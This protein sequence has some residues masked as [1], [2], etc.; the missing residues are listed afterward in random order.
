MARKVHGAKKAAKGSRAKAA[1]V[2]RVKPPNKGIK[3]DLGCGVRP[4]SGFQGVDKH[5][6]DADW[7]IDLLRFPWPWEE[8][9]VSELHCSHFLEHIPAECDA[10]GTDLLVRFMDEAWRVLRTGGKFTVIVPNARSNRAFQDPTHRRFFVAE[11]FA[12]FDANWRA[13]NGLSHYLGRCH[14]RSEITVTCSTGLARLSEAERA[15]RFESH[16]NT[17]YD[18]RVVMTRLARPS[19]ARQRR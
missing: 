18:W 13:Q 6:A 10:S 7:R 4:R 5:A 12:Y 17:I 2:A 14:F 19:A 1:K 16:W 15:R 11:T 9:S 8:E 3:L